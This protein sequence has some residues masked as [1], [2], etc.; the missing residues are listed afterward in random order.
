LAHI[1]DEN[2][3]SQVFSRPYETRAQRLA[4]LATT[5]RP[6][7]GAPRRRRAFLVVP[8]SFNYRESF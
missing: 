6:M 2:L 7:D 5:F 4:R 8:T 3:L 1:E